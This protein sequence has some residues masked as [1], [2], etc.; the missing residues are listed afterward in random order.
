M[1]T[2]VAIREY[3]QTSVVPDPLLE[4]F[5]DL[6]CHVNWGNMGPALY[7]NG[8]AARFE[9]ILQDVYTPYSGEKALIQN[10]LPE[11]SDWAKDISTVIIIGPGPAR[12]IRA[13]ERQILQSLPKLR[14]VV[15]SELSR[16]FNKQSS[17]EIKRLFPNISVTALQQDFRTINL[18]NVDYDSALVISTGG[19]TNFE[20]MTADHFPH[21]QV[22]EHLATIKRLA[23]HGG[24]FLWGYDSSIDVSRYNCPEV[25]EFLLYPLE[26]A[27]KMDGVTLDPRGFEHKTLANRAASVLSH[28]WI[29]T[30]DQN[31]FIGDRSYA[32]SV[33]EKFVAFSSAKPDPT[34]I[35]RAASLQ[36]IVSHKIYRDDTG[37]V[38]HALNCM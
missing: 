17:A 2:A 26:K 16:E 20:R 1:S 34:K 4:R 24:K 9:R 11:I 33:G 29:V 12:S 23:R 18:D 22:S 8:G 30:R 28:D 6:F 5:N 36:G 37:S 7:S 35:I 13:K 21:S 14:Q 19:F 32:F 38:I 10:N 27:S 15:I 3:K 25:S 31:V